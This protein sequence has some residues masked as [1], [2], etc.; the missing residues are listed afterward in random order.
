MTHRRYKAAF[1]RMLVEVLIVIIALG[2]GVVI[3]CSVKGWAR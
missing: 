2:I 1:Y 3:A